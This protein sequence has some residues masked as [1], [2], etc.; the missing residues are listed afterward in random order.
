VIRVADVEAG[1]GQAGR[2]VADDCLAAV[3]KATVSPAGRS[4]AQR[5]RA[6]CP[7]AEAPCL[8]RA[9]VAVP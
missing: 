1:D 3:L 9:A 4:L 8:L 6:R 5:C 2:H 7:A